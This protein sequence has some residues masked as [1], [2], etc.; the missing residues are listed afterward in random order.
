MKITIE[1][2]NHVFHYKH[3]YQ[4]YILDYAICH[5]IDKRYGIDELKA[6]VFL[7][8]ECY[9]KDGNPTPLGSLTDFMAEHWEE[10]HDLSRYEILDK[11]YEQLD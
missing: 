6:F 5:E 7:V 3:G 2:E 4:A 9:L 11:F 8:A 10:I 1:Y